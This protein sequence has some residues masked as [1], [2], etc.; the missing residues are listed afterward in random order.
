VKME[1]NWKVGR[2]NTNLLNFDLVL[3]ELK[4][5]SVGVPHKMEHTLVVFKLWYLILNII[6]IIILYSWISLSIILGYVYCDKIENPT[7]FLIFP[8]LIC[9]S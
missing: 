4:K 7:E 6:I 8:S 5:L 1:R 3:C 2:L 9:F